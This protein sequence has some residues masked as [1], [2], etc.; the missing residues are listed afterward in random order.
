MIGAGRK[1]LKCD[2]DVSD[3]LESVSRARCLTVE[4][5]IGCGANPRLVE[6]S[7]ELGLIEQVPPGSVSNITG[8]C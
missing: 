2:R 5:T 6:R 7:I 3:L 1:A 8:R 4:E